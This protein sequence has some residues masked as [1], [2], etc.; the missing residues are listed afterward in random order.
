MVVRVESPEP[1]TFFFFLFTLVAGPRRSLNLKL[2]DA[3]VCEPQIRARLDT[4]TQ[5]CEVV[6][7]KPSTVAAEPEPPNVDRGS[8]YLRLIDLCIT[9]L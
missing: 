4:T 7:L 6:V 9:Q 8:S 5:F 3:R 2:S 1:S